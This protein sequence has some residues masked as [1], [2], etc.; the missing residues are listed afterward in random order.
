MRRVKRSRF[1]LPRLLLGAAV[2]LV[3]VIALRSYQKDAPVEVSPAFREVFEMTPPPE[4]D[5]SD[6]ALVEAVLTLDSESGMK[7]ENEVAYSDLLNLSRIMAAESGPNWD[8]WAIMAIGEVV[9]NRVSSPE[10]P[11]TISEVLHQKGQYEPVNKNSWS[12]IRPDET[13][14]L[15]ALRL[16]NG[17]R[18]LNDASVVFQA[19]F[20]QGSSV[21]VEYYDKDLE[22]ITYFCRSNYPALY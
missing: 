8:D 22:T 21:A 14:V 15:L 20:E 11:D 5:S 2:L 3:V 7:M 1:L 6:A 9:L 18:V 4:I 10:F 16:L 12:E 13:T 19:L 17:E